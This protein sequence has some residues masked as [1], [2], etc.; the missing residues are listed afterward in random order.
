MKTQSVG[1][2]PHHLVSEEWGVFPGEPPFL[3]VEGRQ[4][5][6][7][8]RSRPLAKASSDQTPLRDLVRQRW[9][10]A[11]GEVEVG[12]TER[13]LLAGCPPI[14]YPNPSS[15]DWPCFISLLPRLSAL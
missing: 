1:P 2:T 7:T 6:E 9:R 11:E 15:G 4:S 13:L 3:L 5:R 14:N 10:E 12:V 8:E